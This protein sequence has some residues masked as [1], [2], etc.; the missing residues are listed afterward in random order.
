MDEIAIFID[1][2]SIAMVAEVDEAKFEAKSA[3]C[4]DAK[5]LH[6]EPYAHLLSVVVQPKGTGAEAANQVSCEK[7]SGSRLCVRRLERLRA[8]GQLKDV[9]TGCCTYPMA[10]RCRW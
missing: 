4:S 6:N 8:H 9:I 5:V 3:L 1:G 10:N 2:V 7:T